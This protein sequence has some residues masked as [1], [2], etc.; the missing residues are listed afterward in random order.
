MKNKDLVFDRSCHVLY[1]KAC[2]KEIKNRISAHYTSENLE[3]VWTEV[4]LKYVEFLKDWRT[5]LGG[6]KLS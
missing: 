2:E 3:R 1:S 6:K 4:Q 5:N